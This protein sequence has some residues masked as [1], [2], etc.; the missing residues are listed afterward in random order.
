M[1]K[2]IKLTAIIFLIPVLVY[3][4]FNT[5]IFYKQGSFNY[6]P[7]RN[8]VAMGDQNNDGYDDFI[9]RNCTTST[10]TLFFG[11]NPM[12]STNCIV[13][14]RKWYT[15]V[16][17]DI[18]GDGKKDIF[19]KSVTDNTFLVY[20]GGNLLDTIPDL[21]ITAPS[22]T[23]LFFGAWM[24]NI[25]D[26]NGDGKD[27][28][29]IYDSYF[30]YSNKEVGINY[31]FSTSPQFDMI[32]EMILSGD[33]VKNIKM[34]AFTYGDLN[35]DGKTDIL[36]SIYDGYGVADSLIVTKLIPGNSFWDTT[37]VQMIYRKKQTF[38][39]ASWRIMKDINGD[40]RDDILIP[41]YGDMYPWWYYNSILYGSIPIDTIQDVG[42]NTQAMAIEMAIGSV[43]VGDVNGDGYNDFLTLQGFGYPIAKLWLGGRDMN[44][45]N[46]PIRTWGNSED[47]FGGLINRVGDVDG[48]GVND[49]AI[50]TATMTGTCKD[51]FFIIIRGDTSVVV[52]VEEELDFQPEGYKLFEPYPNPF[53]PEIT[54]GY[55]VGKTSNI[56]IT[57]FDLL[58]REITKLLEDEE[59]TKGEY[60]IKLN[61]K[62]YNLSSGIYIINMQAKTNGNLLYQSTK[63]VSF[64]K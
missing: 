50:G 48:D 24:T 49:F 61:I 19:T 6:N 45:H 44:R 55:R 41:R 14:P 57:L 43:S 42:L 1:K 8:I 58:G 21:K 63:K 13:F 30:P 26:F 64:I 54:I 2:I 17:I 23:S 34:R 4:Q 47:F 46:V 27:E 39:P 12:D 22:G 35:G 62:D 60:Y 51:G 10:Y 33:T 3:S 52:N 40:G 37:S 38:N 31:F 9:V 29:V 20:Y 15:P 36:Y 18:N 32:P 59:N 53:N 25:G 56:S 7:Y 11:S 16:A 5:V 28:L